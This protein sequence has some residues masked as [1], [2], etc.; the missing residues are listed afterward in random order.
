MVVIPFHSVVP[1]ALD[2]SDYHSFCFFSPHFHVFMFSRPDQ[3]YLMSL[4]KFQELAELKFMR[5][6]YKAA[7]WIQARQG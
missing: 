4:Q 1:F 3:T 2:L 5:R 7:V 6:Q